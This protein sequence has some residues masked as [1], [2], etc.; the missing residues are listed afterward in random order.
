MTDIEQEMAERFY[1]FGRWKA[2]Y[3]FIGPEQGQDKKEDNKLE[4]RLRA[5]E[6]LGK[7]ELAD[8]K[9]FHDL[10][11]PGMWTEES[12]PLQ[13]TW[14]KLMLVL[15]S[16][17]PGLFDNEDL[18]RYQ[19]TRLGRATGETCLLELSGLPANSGKI[20]RDR[21]SFLDR[22]IARLKCAIETYEPKLVVMYGKGHQK[23]FGE[24]AKPLPELDRAALVGKTLILFTTHTNARGLSD[25]HWRNL[26]KALSAA[27]KST[28]QEN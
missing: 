5:W 10:L 20:T 14:R 21:E 3:W 1:G 24:I 17:R 23:Q 27:A 19:R 13:K 11:R 2:P 12:A 15:L 18:R 22:R 28:N 9:D 6:K 7:P 8:L 25:E 26:G 4:P 16:S